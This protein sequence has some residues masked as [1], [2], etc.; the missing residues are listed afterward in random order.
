MPS[1]RYREIYTA[2]FILQ[3]LLYLCAAAGAAL[4]GRG[5]IKIFYVCWYFMVIDIAALHAFVKLLGG[6]KQVICNPRLG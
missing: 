3:C 2:S 1:A 4:S 5:V 6:E